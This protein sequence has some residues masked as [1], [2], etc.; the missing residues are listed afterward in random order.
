MR[1]KSKTSC[2]LCSVI[3]F[4]LTIFTLSDVI[5][6]A[7]EYTRVGQAKTSG[8]VKE[9]RL[10]SPVNLGGVLNLEVGEDDVC[11]VEFECW[12]RAKNRKNAKEFT[13]LVQINLE[14][15]GQVVTLKLDTPRNAPWE[16]TN[17]AIKVTLDVYVPRDIAV[18][19]KTRHFSLDI[20]GPLRTVEIRNSYGE[21]RIADV[22]EQT[23][24][25][26]SYAQVDAE[27]IRG[28]LD[29]ET[30]YNRISVQ[31]V[32][33][34]GGKAFLK[35]SYGEIDV[36][37]FTGQLEAYTVYSPIY[38]SGMTLLGGG[39]E[40]KTVYSKI[41]LGFE[42]ITDSRLY[43]YNSYGNIDLAVPRDLS[44]RLALSVGRGGKINTEGILIKPQVIEKTRLEGIC[45]DGDSEIE[46]NISGIGR[47]LVEGR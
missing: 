45:G 12:A 46:L 16:G 22:T 36:D 31:N 24:V 13:E 39:N 42:E 26:G 27:N 17:Y 32:D 2:W 28:D 14:R 9:F 10:T 11:S 37:D 43:V 7:D 41:E 23:S 3:L 15:V 33:T 19:A 8:E 25:D 47:I 20:T 1:T 35:T 21:I 29:I 34:E 18:E 30:S 4:L 6:A 40:I 38:G 44:A 5:S